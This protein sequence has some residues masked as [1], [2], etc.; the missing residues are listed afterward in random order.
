MCAVRPRHHTSRR[1]SIGKHSGERHD[2]T[3]KNLRQ[4][5]TPL[6][7]R[8]AHQARSTTLFTRCF[9]EVYALDLDMRVT[10]TSARGSRFIHK[11]AVG[12]DRI[13]PH[14]RVNCRY[15]NNNR[16]RPAMGGNRDDFCPFRRICGRRVWPIVCRQLKRSSTDAS[17]DGTGRPTDPPQPGRNGPPPYLSSMWRDRS[18]A[19][20]P[21]RRG[22][23]PHPRGPLGTA[24]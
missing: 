10:S 1:C 2:S 19:A 8:G 6:P 17:A 11:P 9:S 7:T 3:S 15:P 20:A 18:C 22:P 16:W 12:V 24:Q 13:H 23:A 14:R 4:T 5:T 21:V